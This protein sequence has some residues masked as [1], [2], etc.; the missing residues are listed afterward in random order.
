MPGSDEPRSYLVEWYWPG[1]SIEKLAA[2]AGRTQRAANEFRGQGRELRFCGSMLVPADETVFCFFDGEEA[3][4]RTISEQV[5][6][7][8]ERVL[9]LLWI[10]GK[11]REEEE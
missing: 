3:N 10:D 2:A 7:P 4:V 1:V 9:K 6:V 5:G 11:Q 8:F